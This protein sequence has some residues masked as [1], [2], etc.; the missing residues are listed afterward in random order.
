MFGCGYVQ[1]GCGAINAVSNEF[2]RLQR[3]CMIVSEYASRIKIAFSIDTFEQLVGVC[4]RLEQRSVLPTIDIYSR[5]AEHHCHGRL[6][7]PRL[8]AR[9]GNIA[10]TASAKQLLSMLATNIVIDKPLSSVN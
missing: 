5:A 9:D 4:K 2:V 1:V 3:L 6:H 8:A 10:H 7:T